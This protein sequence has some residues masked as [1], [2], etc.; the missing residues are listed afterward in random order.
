M[1]DLPEPKPTAAAAGQ[2]APT[3]ADRDTIRRLMAAVDE[4]AAEKPTAIRI[5]DPS[6]PSWED[7]SRIG[8]TPP[9]DQ[10]G[11]SSMSS[12]AVDDSVRMWSFGGTAVL[13]CGG[14]SLVMVASE[15]ADPTVIG[16]FFGGLA[17]LALAI[18][19]LLRRAG[20]AAPAETHNHISGDVHVDRREVKNKNTGIWVKNTND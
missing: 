5:D 19:R 4:L 8:T 15:K 14:V 17:V 6:V 1:Y 9:V 18:A 11:R 16:V 7:G 20:Q 12:K 10:P 2:A 13:V 3:D